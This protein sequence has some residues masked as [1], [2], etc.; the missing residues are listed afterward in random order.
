MSRLLLDEILPHPDHAIAHAAVFRVRPEQSFTAALDLDILRNPFVRMLV[1][2]RGSAA[3]GERP[4]RLSLRD[5]T[6]PPLGW[7]RLADDPG[8]E[9]VLGQVSRPWRLTDGGAVHSL[10]PEAFRDFDRPGYAKVAV[11]LRAQPHGAAGSILTI[12]TRVVLTDASSRSR[13]RRYWLVVRPFSE[14]IRRI[15]FRQLRAQLDG[16]K[17]PIRGEI[18]ILRPPEVVFDTVA[19]ERNEPRFNPALTRVEKLTA[20]PLGVGTRFRAEATVRGRI[21][22]MTIELTEFVRAQ[23]LSSV[24]QMAAMRIDG[25]LTFGPTPR[26]TRMTWAWNIHPVGALALARPAVV[27]MGRRQEVR[28]WRGLKDHLEKGPADLQAW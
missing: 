16:T 22:P 9:L 5:M 19:D 1:A 27:W 25:T 28:I 15:A 2:A 11:S 14:A 6:S 18:E 7:L 20:G 21:A 13:F 8:T 24:T 26:G 10:S 4:Q 17:A 12:E 23:R 3:G